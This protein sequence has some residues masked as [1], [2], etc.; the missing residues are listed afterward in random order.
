MYNG[1]LN[2]GNEKRE[3]ENSERKIGNRDSGIVDGKLGI[4]NPN[5]GSEIWEAGRGG[6]R[7][8]LAIS[9]AMNNASPSAAPSCAAKARVQRLDRTRGRCARTEEVRSPE[10]STSCNSARLE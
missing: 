8:L 10:S 9:T 1:A 6:M 7:R 4:A 3:I 5:S 2:V